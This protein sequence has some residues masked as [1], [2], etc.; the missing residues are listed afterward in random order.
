MI[1]KIGHPEKTDKP[2]WITTPEQ[3]I[4][5]LIKMVKT[6]RQ[7][8]AIKVLVDHINMGEDKDKAQHWL[9]AK[10]LL[11][12]FNKN[13]L[14]YKD[15]NISLQSVMDA[16]KVPMDDYFQEMNDNISHVQDLTPAM[17]E[18]DTDKATEM[19]LKRRH[20]MREDII[21]QINLIL[22]NPKFYA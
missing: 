5:E 4:V 12:I 3:A 2:K 6:K 7:E 21:K 11:Y 16:L 19:I 20:D 15:G 13:Y 18:M 22:N 17:K 10:L 8:R 1:K 14:H 9:F